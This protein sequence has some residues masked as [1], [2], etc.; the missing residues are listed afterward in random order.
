MLD[1]HPC[2]YGMNCYGIYTK[3]I[4]DVR[5]NIYLEEICHIDFATIDKIS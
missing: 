5:Y 4:A 2:G 3:L 1:D